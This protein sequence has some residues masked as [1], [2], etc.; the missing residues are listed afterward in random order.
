[1]TDSPQPREVDF[2]QLPVILGG[3]HPNAPT[4][5]DLMERYV[6]PSRALLDEAKA[7]WASA[8]EAMFEAAAS[9]EVYVGGPGQDGWQHIGTATDGM[10]W[11]EQPGDSA[12]LAPK[13]TAA[14]VLEMKLAGFRPAPQFHPI[15]VPHSTV[16]VTYRPEEYHACPYCGMPTEGVDYEAAKLEAMEPPAVMVVDADRLAPITITP[17][18]ITHRPCGHSLNTRTSEWS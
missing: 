8:C 2:D 14:V 17:E 13:T 15:E 6:A 3:T 1:M 18:T 10:R 4:T 12:P 5:A 9:A 16:R 7:R 11:E